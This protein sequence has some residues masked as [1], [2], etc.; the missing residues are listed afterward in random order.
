MNSQTRDNEHS[1]GTDCSTSLD[2]GRTR[3]SG[4][5]FFAVP[6]GNTET[7]RAALTRQKKIAVDFTDDDVVWLIYALAKELGPEAAS[8]I[9]YNL[10]K[11]EF[12]CLC[13]ES[14]TRVELVDGV[15]MAFCRECG[16][17]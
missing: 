16:E 6:A 9:G 13:G 11:C 17:T 1:A 2:V 10:A 14:P 7:I 5:V 15:A 12:C 4:R 8:L 3:P